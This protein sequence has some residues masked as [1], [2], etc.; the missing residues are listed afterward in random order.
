MANDIEIVLKAVDE[1]SADIKSVSNEIDNLDQSS[2]ESAEGVDSFSSS[3]AAAG[4]AAIALVTAVAAATTAVVALGVSAINSAREAVAGQNQ[5]QAVLKSTEGVA[6][7]TAD[8]VN[9]LASSLSLTTNFTDDA[10]LSAENLLLTFTQIGKDVFPDA[11]KVILDM[12]TAM[13]TDL[14]SSAIQVGKALNDPINGIASLSRVGVQ[15]TDDQKAVIESLVNT[16]KTAEAQALILA[17]LT[18]EFGGSAEALADPIIQIK[19]QVGELAEAIGLKLLPV[20]NDIA[21]KILDWID[22]QGGAAAIIDKITA[23]LEKHK[24]ALIAVGV[25]LSGAFVA[26]LLVATAALIAFLGPMIAAT[27]ALLPF[28]AV[29]AIV[30]G[31]IYVIVRG[32]QAFIALLPAIKEVWGTVWEAVV[33]AFESAKDAVVGALTDLWN[34]IISVW[35]GI[36]SFISTV[37]ALI[38]GIVIVAFDALGI[39][40]IAVWQSIK[41][42]IEFALNSIWQVIQLIL[43]FISTTWS[44]T[45]NGVVEVITTVWSAITNTI[46]SALGAIKE[47]FTPALDALA[48]AWNNFWTGAAN[49][50]T[51]IWEGVKATVK[52]GINNV[53]SQLNSIISAVNSV[54]AKGASAL[55][56]K[57][58]SIPTIPLLAKGGNILGAGSVIVGEQGP[59]LLD[60]PR[61]ARVTPLS[62][63]SQGLGSITINVTGNQFGQNM[64]ARDVAI[65]MGN[66]IMRELKLITRV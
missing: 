54:M 47:F 58:V 23:F 26:A 36:K 14:K 24:E 66:Q 7:V 32:I 17:E 48:A 22:A 56:I 11:T 40:I 30:A 4:P 50:V 10:I 2:R 59:E 25:V 1:A 51:N 44:N 55:G 8:A 62:G 12:S 31:G 34:G 53:I 43:E 21:G 5:L 28:I 63:G 60:L 35:E 42:G 39:D 52:A 65:A 20:V 9:E 19:N 61:G 57:V 16:G 38:V 29:G 18:K 33:G 41:L 64:S 37:I 27:A 45:W 46:G 3:V 49:T 13:G 15:F 6:G